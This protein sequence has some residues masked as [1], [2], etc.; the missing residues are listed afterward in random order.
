[1]HCIIVLLYVV[2]LCSSAMSAFGRCINVYLHY[3]YY[4]Y[5][6]MVKKV[7]VF[8]ILFCL[9][10]FVQV[11]HLRHHVKIGVLQGQ[12]LKNFRLRVYSSTFGV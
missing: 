2:L 1:M 6:V 12:S 7:L 9:L 8:L 10:D 3:Y 4:Y 11:P 5:C